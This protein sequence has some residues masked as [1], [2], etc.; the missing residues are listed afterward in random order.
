MQTVGLLGQDGGAL[1]GL[2]DRAIVVDSVTTARIQETHNF[3]LH[4][5]AWRI[6]SGL[7]R[8][9]GDQL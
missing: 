1:K 9:R 6:E 8:T 3:I 7:P 4:Y 2:V 5:W